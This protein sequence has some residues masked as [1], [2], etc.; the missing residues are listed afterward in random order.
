MKIAVVGAGIIGITT[1]WELARDGHQ[2]TVYERRG[3]AAEESS[4]AN[5]GV[6]APGAVAPWA[7][8]GMPSK[9]LRYLLS[10]HAPVR[11]A[12]PLSASELAL[13]EGCTT[14]TLESDTRATTGAMS[15]IGSN[16]ILA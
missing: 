16:G 2:V 7:A 14:S 10:S 3:A 4:F 8:P 11:L 12:L 13:T 15:L 6:M 5:A 1:A 9:V